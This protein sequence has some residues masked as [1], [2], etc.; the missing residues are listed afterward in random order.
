M[1]RLSLTLQLIPHLHKL[2]S[3]L[4]MMILF[5]ENISV[6][7]LDGVGGEEVEECD[8]GGHDFD[9]VVGV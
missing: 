3:D 7:E 9:E 8:E 4:I 2:P 6:F 1:S 5:L